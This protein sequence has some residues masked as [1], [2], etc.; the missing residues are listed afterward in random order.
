MSLNKKIDGDLIKALKG[1]D[2]DKVTLLRGLKSDIKY[3]RIE[4]GDDL[5]EEEIIAVLSTAAK[6][7]RDSIEQFRNGDRMD[8]ADK[9]SA[10]LEVI[11]SYLP[12]QLS[13][14]KLFELVRESIEA[15]Q[16]DSPAKLGLV[17]KDLMPK[18][19][20]KADGKLINQLVS[21]MLSGEKD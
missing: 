19:K 5:T 17:M 20:G 12:E 9:E 16:A 1:G 10:E 15:T 21:R 13:E 11:K 14:E 7:R 2:K 3:K 4:K 8:L 6:Q 18:V